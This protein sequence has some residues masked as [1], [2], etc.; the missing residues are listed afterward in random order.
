MF[1]AN[2]ITS[3]LRGTIIDMA[4]PKVPR[5]HF[6]NIIYAYKFQKYYY[7]GILGEKGNKVS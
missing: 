7:N 3:F 5:L 2:D 4:S 6:I 1:S